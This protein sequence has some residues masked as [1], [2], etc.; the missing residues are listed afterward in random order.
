MR[1]RNLCVEITDEI[2]AALK[3][4]QDQEERSSVGKLFQ[5]RGHQKQLPGIIVAYGMRRVRS[6]PVSGINLP[7]LLLTADPTFY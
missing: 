1:Q 3:T 4:A 6:K 7:S 5:V 2:S